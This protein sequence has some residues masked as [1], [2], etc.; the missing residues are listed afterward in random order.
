[1][2]S[3]IHLMRLLRR[4]GLEDYDD[5]SDNVHLMRQPNGPSQGE[6]ALDPTSLLAT[7]SSLNSVR[8][9]GVMKRA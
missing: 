8:H 1:M 6:K 2:G 5:D 3:R 7:H 4:L 9:P